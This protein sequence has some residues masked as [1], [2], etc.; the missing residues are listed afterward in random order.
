MYWKL[1]RI[2][3]P[4]YNLGKGKRISVWVQGCSFG[5]KGCISQT[6]QTKKGG[7]L[8]DIENLVYKISKVA[9]QFDGVTITGGEPFQQYKELIAFCAWLKQQ[10]NL[11]IYVF[12]GYYLNELVEL[13]P[14]RLFTKYI[15]FLMDGRYVKEDHHNENIKGSGNQA[16]YQFVDNDVIK[17]KNGFSS[18]EFGLSVDKDNQVYLS[19]IP[20]QNDL[21]QLNKFL[22]QTG[23][24]ITFK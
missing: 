4:V 14:D 1:N 5:C 21:N 10:T 13:F 6:L 16:L 17:L 7:K 2:Q 11:E 8:V 24:D 12:S 9:D 3:Y 15:D 23:I 19:G 18:D 22:T 20:K